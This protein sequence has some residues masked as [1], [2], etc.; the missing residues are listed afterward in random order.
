MNGVDSKNNSKRLQKESDENHIINQNNVTQK[1]LEKM[2]RDAI[3]KFRSM[4]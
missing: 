3:K 2:A 1:D 4:R